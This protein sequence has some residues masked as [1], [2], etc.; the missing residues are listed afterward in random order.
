MPDSL[1]L[2]ECN[3]SNPV[4]D[5]ANDYK[6]AR[7]IEEL[8]Q[9]L[10]EV[11]ERLN[12]TDLHNQLVA[13]EEFNFS[14]NMKGYTLITRSGDRAMEIHNHRQPSGRVESYSRIRFLKPG[15]RLA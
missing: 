9:A 4:F 10:M 1:K 5:A 2:M 8:K 7:M 13:C 15:C 14:V 12:E 6:N 3:M 11:F